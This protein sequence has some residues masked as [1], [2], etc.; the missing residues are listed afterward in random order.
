MTVG[1]TAI[2]LAVIGTMMFAISRRRRSLSDAGAGRLILW[3]G[4][5]FP[6]V[7][8]LFLLGF[9][10]WLMPGLRPF[11]APADA[12]LRVDVTGKQFWWQVAYNLPDGSR[13]HAANEVRLPVGKRVEFAL[14]SDDVI[15]SFWIPALG[16]KMDMIPGRTNR[17]SLLATK[18][19]TFRSPCA[20]FCGTS[21]ALMA[22]SAVAMEPTEFDAWLAAHARPAA[23]ATGEGREAFLRNGCGACHRVDGTE[24][25]ATIGP[26]LSHVGSRLTIG[27]GI[28]PNTE[29]AIARFIADPGAIKP[30]AKMPAFGMLP[31]EEIAAMAA[32]LKGLE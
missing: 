13:V 28:L 31:A 1:S 12:S 24:A 5:V 30:D 27:A 18:P 14:A 16:G 8:L 15:H 4:A 21:H 23:G 2:W 22:L 9:A 7:T 20:E 6:S 19:G 29:T 10:L 11:A 17:L 32:W 25:N 3:G 26:D